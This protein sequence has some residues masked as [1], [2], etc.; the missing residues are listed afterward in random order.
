MPK[1]PG[2]SAAPSS[3]KLP[4]SWSPQ[5]ERVF[6]FV[7]SQEGNGLIEAVAGSGKTTTLLKVAELAGNQVGFFAYNKKI[8]DEIASKLSGLGLTNAKSQTMHAVGMK[9]LGKLLGKLEVAADKTDGVLEEL[10][11]P[12]YYRAAIKKLLSLG[13]Q[14]LL[15]SDIK[16]SWIELMDHFDVYE[17]MPE[18][19][20]KSKKDPTEE[21]IEWTL[22]ALYES[23]QQAKEGLIDFDDMI[24]ESI[25]LNA[26]FP[27]FDWV[28]LDEAQDTN[29]ARRQI[30]AQMLRPDSRLIAVGDRHQA[31]YGFTGASADSLDLIANMFQCGYLPLTVTYRCPKAVVE[32]ARQWVSHIEAHPSAP[33]GS[34]ESLTAFDFFKRKLSSTDAILCR[35]NKPLVNLAFGFI[36]NKVACHIEGRDIGQGLIT[37]IR[38]WKSV[39]NIGELHG[40]LLEYRDSQCERLRARGNHAKAA[41]IT[42]KVDTIFVLMEGFAQKD[43]TFGLISLINSLFLDSEGKQLQSIT[44]STVHKSKGREW[45]R[46]YLWGRQLYMPSSFAKQ[47]WE[48]EQERNLIYVAVTRAKEEL[49]EVAVGGEE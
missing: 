10:D 47:T 36:R 43:N 37:L 31:I 38:K 46:V 26:P 6:G 24:Y 13:K 17:L 32:H 33:E 2:M 40:K 23:R 3:P 5:Q 25:M 11:A 16:D 21:V 41:S 15:T 12:F 44:L 30:A 18:Q 27:T 20:F 4:T 14:H 7:K 29:A 1:I 9:A 28:L 19:K 35:N 39:T 8:A 22:K 48:L 49:V 45:N 34:V 42:D